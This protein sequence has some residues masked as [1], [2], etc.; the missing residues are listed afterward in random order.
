MAQCGKD[1]QV[2]SRVVGYYR[3]VQ[4]WNKGKESEFSE[5]LEYDLGKSFEHAER[6][7]DKP[8][9]KQGGD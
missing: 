7:G 1:C 8:L 3:P 5:R 6:L 9:E 4:A 2:Y